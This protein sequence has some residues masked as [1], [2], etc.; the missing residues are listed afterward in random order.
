MDMQESTTDRT[1][2]EEVRQWLS[3][4]LTGEFA[5]ARGAGWP[6]REHEALDVRLAWERRLGDAG[7]TCLGLPVEHGG[8]G[9]SVQQQVIFHEEY[10]E[11]DAP[12]RVGVIGEGM[13]APTLAAYGTPEQQAPLPSADRAW[14]DHV[15]PVLLRAGS[16]IGPREHLNSS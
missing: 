11:A 5:D 7:W 16:R 13:V 1:F 12:V 9:L 3:D 15:V 2:R 14:R 8:R 10:A 4:N 6:G